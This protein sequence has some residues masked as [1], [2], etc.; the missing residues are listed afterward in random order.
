MLRGLAYDSDEAR[1]FTGA[2]TA[3]MTGE[4]Y[5]TSAEMAQL[6]GPSRNTPRTRRTC[7]GSSATIAAPP[8]TRRRTSTRV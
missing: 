3:I 1:A 7:C 5:A 2:M 8:T 6:L 4:S